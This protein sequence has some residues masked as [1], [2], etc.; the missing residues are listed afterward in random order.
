MESR[1]V[2]HRCVLAQR[3]PRVDQ[4]Q[5]LPWLLSVRPVSL[6]LA[7][8]PYRRAILLGASLLIFLSPS[9]IGF[10]SC[11][12]ID[13][14]QQRPQR[15]NQPCTATSTG[16]CV[17][18]DGPVDM[19]VKVQ[20][21]QIRGPYLHLSY[22]IIFLPHYHRR[23]SFSKRWVR[24]RAVLKIVSA[25]PCAP[26]SRAT[27]VPP[28]DL[29]LPPQTPNLGHPYY[30]EHHRSPPVGERIRLPFLSLYHVRF[31]E[32]DLLV[33]SVTEE[34]GKRTPALL[35]FISSCKLSS[36]LVCH[37]LLWTLSAH[38]T[39]RPALL[40]L[41]KLSCAHDGVSPGSCMSLRIMPCEASSLGICMSGVRPNLVSDFSPTSLYLYSQF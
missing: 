18:V 38:G 33:H 14:L 35:E 32:V 29:V 6:E 40:L 4:G 11:F 12:M 10:F 19:A 16:D 39:R 28:S 23:H 25:V 7:R 8:E 15:L 5:R 22:L 27:G 17:G 24:S 34:L 20:V 2:Q 13:L 31:D 30:N 9:L 21:R 3:T 26:P 1:D 41:H 37:S 36:V